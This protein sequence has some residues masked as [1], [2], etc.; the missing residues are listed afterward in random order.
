MAKRE[1]RR[2]GCWKRQTNHLSSLV[3]SI[4]TAAFLVA[5][6]SLAE[7]AG[8]RDF[9]IAPQELSAALKAYADQAKVQ[10]FYEQSLVAGRRSGG[11]SGAFPRDAA[12]AAVLQGT[13]LAFAFSGDSTV[14]VR[15][16]GTRQSPPVSEE[17]PAPLAPAPRQEETGT[18][19]EGAKTPGAAPQRQSTSVIEEIVITAQRREESLQKAPVSVTAFDAGTIRKARIFGLEDVAL[20]TPGFT[21]GNFSPEAPNLTLRGIGS[22]DRD[23]GS[24]RSVVVFVDEVYIGRAGASTFDLFDLERVEVLHGPQG[25]LYGKNVVGGAVNLITH[26]PEAGTSAA[27]EAGLGNYDFFELRGMLN[28]DMGDKMQARVAFSSRARDGFQ[29][30]ARTG[31]DVDTANNASARGHV[32]FLAT[33]DLTFLLS[34]DYAR[35]R[36]YGVSRKVAPTGPFVAFLGFTPDPD[37]RIVNDNVDGFFDR[38]IV[39]VSGRADWTT[40]VGVLTSLTAYRDMTSQVVQDVVGIPLDASFDAQGRPRGFLSIDDTSEDYGAFSQEVRLSSLPQAARWTWVVGLYYSREDVDRVSVRDRSLLG[41]T[42]KPKFD[43]A[44][45]TNSYAVFGQ[46]TYA[47]TSY[48]NATAGARYTYDRKNFALAVSDASGGRADNLNP[49]TEVF[50]IT[51][52]DDWDAFTPRFALDFNP[53]DDVMVFASVSRGFKSG[54]FQGFAP[55]AR[56]ARISFNPEFAWNYEAGIKSQWLDQ[57]LRLN[58]TG[59]YLSFSDLQFRQRV[60]TVP[61]DES[62]AVVIILNASDAQ[63]NGLEASFAAVPL[64][65]LTL[66]GSYAYLD[67]EVKNFL[68]GVAGV[69]P[70]VPDLSGNRLALAPRHA[71][72]LSGE[73]R[74]A[75]NDW[76]ELSLRADYSYRGDFFF[77]VENTPPAL[78]KSYGTLDGRIALASQDGRW[79]LSLWAKNLTDTLYRSQVQSGVNGTIGISRFGDPRT[80]GLS[81]AWRYN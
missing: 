62:S 12:L 15:E 10:M 25:T 4:G 40:G 49:A 39:G 2:G 42:S 29:T 43:Q 22:T 60:L 57:R 18:A 8:L 7:E 63:I 72:T 47:L 24:D 9:D 73:Y 11:V 58:L 16:R 23:A 66:S 78:E 50:A 6:A 77:E 68:K 37:P 74:T 35:D 75:V 46:A 28:T 79:E 56:S 61:G 26:K 67:T 70:G 3:L 1:N 41:R 19:P 80:F 17:A 81:L 65:G 32:R 51:A 27:L 59:F 5:R 71:F 13:G 31:N 53:S 76:G 48:L 55:D 45:V 21:I 34:A 20:R 64:P 33:D 38:D 14:I 44:N 69:P 36:I 54:G 52:R 30:N